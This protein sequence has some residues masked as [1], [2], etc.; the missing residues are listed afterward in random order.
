M[1]ALWTL[2]SFAF[3]SVRLAQAFLLRRRGGVIEPWDEG[4]RRALAAKT[5]APASVQPE[6]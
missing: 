1:V 6:A 2:V 3:H 5:P 4:M